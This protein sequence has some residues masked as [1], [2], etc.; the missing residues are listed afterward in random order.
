MGARVLVIDDEEPARY[1]ILRALSQA[2]YSLEQAQNGREAL[3]K[4]ASFQ[5][6]VI[7]SDINMPEMDGLTLLGKVNEGA[8]PPLVVMITAYGSETM[9]M[10]ALRLGAFDYLP[11]P[12]EI[13]ELR[14]IV[15]N[16]VERQRLLRENR[17]F[18]AELR[19]S[20][21]DLVHEKN[22]ASL[23]VLVGGVA[24]E[25]NNP[26]GAL[27]SSV[28]TAQLA[29]GKLRAALGAAAPEGA[30][31]A[32]A[33]WALE[34]AL[35]Q[36]L[37]A[38]ERVSEMVKKLQAFAQLDRAGEERS[39][40]HAGL[41]SAMELLR[42]RTSGGITIVRDYGELPEYQH[43]SRDLNLAFLNLLQNA[44]EAIERAGGQGEIKVGTRLEG[45]AIRI[46]VSD[47]GGGIEPEAAGR[48]FEP[49]FSTKGERV[50]F[51]LGLAICDRVVRSRGGRIEVESTPGRGSTFTVVLPEPRR[52]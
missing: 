28:Q 29:A 17:R 27:Q 43:T 26:L 39:S 20:Y 45:G 49:G 4:I 5:P 48:L 2:G 32:N 33:L 7:V 6:D 12:F 18:D 42:Y 51:G 14:A 22:M 46:S 21:A 3:E 34:A 9:A 30:G 1:G 19:R 31:T 23:A 13:D 25:I 11:K 35:A 47:T 36:S 38:C 16:A 40:L 37:D 50:G 15:R 24:H 44:V 52:E 8:D 10:E 41:D